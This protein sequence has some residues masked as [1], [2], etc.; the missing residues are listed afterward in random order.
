[1]FSLFKKGR[2]EAWD[3]VVVGKK[4][5]MSNAPGSGTVMYYFLMLRLAD[6]STKRVRVHRG[7][8]KSVDE[9]DRVVKAAGGKPMKK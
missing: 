7:M 6:G 5:G 3:G 9:G 8:F 2:D 4:R 1:M